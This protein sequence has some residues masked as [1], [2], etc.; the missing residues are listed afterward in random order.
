MDGWLVVDV[1]IIG[2]G[3]PASSFEVDSVPEES[4]SMSAALRRAKEFWVT[5]YLRAKFKADNVL[6]CTAAF[7]E[8][9]TVLSV[10]RRFRPRTSWKPSSCVICCPVA[11]G[12]LVWP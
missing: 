6:V 4:V 10:A 7:F 11:L 2:G 3:L 9:P 5:I 1:R 8:V 12:E